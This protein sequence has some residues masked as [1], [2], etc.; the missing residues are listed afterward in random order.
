MAEATRHLPG[1]GRLG[2]LGL[3]SFAAALGLGALFVSGSTGPMHL[4]AALG[5]PT[6]S[7]FPSQRAMSPLRWGPR[8]NRH[9]ALSPAG[10]GWRSPRGMSTVDHISVDEAVNAAAFL[11]RGA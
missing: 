11:L 9:G 7:L 1:A 6:L 3:R 2:P 10:L 4:A 5:T 8:G